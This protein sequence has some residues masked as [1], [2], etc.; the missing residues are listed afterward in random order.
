M[1]KSAAARGRI[2]ISYRREETAYPAGWLFD[3]LVDHY[4][5][6]QVFKDID[7]I[8]PG[9][10]F[11]DAIADAVGSC[12]VLLALI[13]NQWLTVP[14]EAGGRRI[15]NPA[16]FVRLEIEAALSRKVRVVPVLVAGAKMP[17]T[18]DLPE[19]LATLARRHALE[20]S[21][22]HFDFE[23]SRLLRVIDETLG[24]G[25]ARASTAENEAEESDPDAG[26]PVAPIVHPPPARRATAPSW[27]GLLS[28]RRVLVAAAA[29]AVALAVLLSLLL[30]TRGSSGGPSTKAA[31]FRDD[32]ST[33][34]YGWNDAGEQRDGGHYVAGA[35]RL[36]SRWTSD[37]FSDEGLP[38]K[39]TSVF[40]VA[41]RDVL[42]TV[43]A[44]RLLGGDQDAGFG[45][46]CRSTTTT[47]SYYQLAIW[48]DQVVIAKVTP[49]PPYYT[50]LQS[51]GDMSAVTANGENRMQA[52]CTTDKSGAAN[53]ELTVNGRVVARA[54]DSDRPLATGTVG[55]AVATGGEGVKAIEAQFDDFVVKPA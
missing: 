35:Y 7:S 53:L 30:V 26:A 12:D 19:S 52:L 31:I 50:T 34:A 33:R 47:E 5:A 8:E 41:P 25:Q 28:S 32:F 16:D 2:F 11:V 37:H 15:D 54:T 21:P 42:V 24:E 51:S 55:L 40:P 44:R 9:D 18:E 14:D 29:V 4:G 46:T 1:D 27:R 22:S 45:I 43:V 39:A 20:L 48:R 36:Y 3:R 17:R 49:A 23:T 6:G 13:G 10:D 38:H